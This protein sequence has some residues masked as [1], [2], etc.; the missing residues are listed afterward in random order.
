MRFRPED[1]YCKPSIAR[2][3]K[4]SN[5]LLKVKRRRLKTTKPKDS[6]SAAGDGEGV[7]EKRREDD[8]EAMELG[9]SG[10]TAAKETAPDSAEGNGE[11]EE[12]KYSMELLGIVNTTYQFSGKMWVQFQSS[13]VYDVMHTMI[14]VNQS[15]SDYGKGEIKWCLF[16]C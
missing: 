12:Y 16:F 3:N 9:S 2:A 14:I 10:G 8:E 1:Q 15:M 7:D 13:V 6:K 5:L 4:T 11:Q